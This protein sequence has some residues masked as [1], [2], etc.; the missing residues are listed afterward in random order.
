MVAA[1]VAFTF[2]NNLQ[3]QQILSQS[4]DQATIEG[5]ISC[6][7]QAGGFTLENSYYRSYVMADYG[8]TSD[9]EIGGVQFGVGSA[10]APIALTVNIYLNS[11]N[12]FPNGTMALIGTKTQNV[13]TADAGTLV[14]ANMGSDNIMVPASSEIVLEIKAPDLTAVP[15]EFYIGGN[16]LGESAQDYLSSPGCGGIAPTPVESL[17][18]DFEHDMIVNL[19][20]KGA[21]AIQNQALTQ[22]SLYPNPV[23]GQLNINLPSSVE[24][25]S[26]TMFDLL[27]KA[28]N[29]NI[30]ENNTLNTSNLATG[31]YILKLETTQGTLTKKVIKQ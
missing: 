23:Q 12:P 13:N 21:L 18:T 4:T 10:T 20:E 8:I 22:I 25:E 27:G 26:A 16:D 28:T 11:G 2:S 29:M 3:A 6:G 17:G 9:F 24:L 14:F 15:A 31:V 1:M 30:S 7:N 5:G 19:V